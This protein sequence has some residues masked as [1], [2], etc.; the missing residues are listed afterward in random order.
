MGFM[1]SGYYPPGAEH[2]PRAPYNQSEDDWGDD[3]EREHHYACAL[4]SGF[5]TYRRCD[6]YLS[7]E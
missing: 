7:D 5:N 3:D 6:C 1:E 4:L 2:D